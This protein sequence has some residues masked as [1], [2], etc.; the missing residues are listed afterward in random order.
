[1]LELDLRSIRNLVVCVC[2]SRQVR[3][4]V[5]SGENNDWDGMTERGPYLGN[6]FPGGVV[7]VEEVV[8]VKTTNAT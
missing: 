5:A 7:Q 8:V 3:L 1:M 6:S 4:A 2:L